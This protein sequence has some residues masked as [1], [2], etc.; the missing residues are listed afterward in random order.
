MTG[1][2]V[3]A[4]LHCGVL[5]QSNIH[6][7]LGSAVS[8]FDRIMP[9]PAQLT[10]PGIRFASDWARPWFGITVSM[11]A[12]PGDG[13]SILLASCNAILSDHAWDSHR[14]A[15]PSGI[16][17]PG[18]LGSSCSMA[19]CH[20]VHSSTGA[21]VASPVNFSMWL[22]LHGCNHLDWYASTLLNMQSSGRF[23]GPKYVLHYHTH[24]NVCCKAAGQSPG[25]Q[26]NKY[27]IPRSWE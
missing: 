19:P 23:C 11:L 5:C 22:H 17:R 14:L 3:Q 1:G 9:V 24:L 18:S 20:V 12:H 6:G 7:Q 16:S 15:T 2:V 10:A 27:T 13:Q 4:H 21:A 25:W 8:H 26:K